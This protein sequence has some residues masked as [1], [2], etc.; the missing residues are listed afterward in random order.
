MYSASASAS[1]SANSVLVQVPVTRSFF[2]FH[3]QHAFDTSVERVDDSAPL[4]LLLLYWHTSTTIPSTSTTKQARGDKRHDPGRPPDQSQPLPWKRWNQC[5]RRSLF[6]ML[7]DAQFDGGGDATSISCS[8]CSHSILPPSPALPT[9]VV[10]ARRRRGKAPPRRAAA[11]LCGG[12]DLPTFS[13]SAPSC[14][15]PCFSS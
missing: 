10:A 8:R 13:A 7:T 15:P 12:T 2:G 11:R 6:A 1:A 14:Y 9:L 5:K 4:T 3:E